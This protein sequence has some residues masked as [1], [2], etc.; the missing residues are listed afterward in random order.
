MPSLVRCLGM[1]ALSGLLPAAAFAQQAPQRSYDGDIQLIRPVYG[2]ENLPG[3]DVPI[4]WRGGSAR[5]G[6]TFMYEYQPLMLREFGEEVGPIIANRF[7]AYAGVSVDITRAVTARITMP[8]HVNW[9]TQVP[10][11][12][13]D[14]F[15][16]GDLG[17]GL[18]WAFLRKPV[19]SLGLRLDIT[20]P[21]SR[22]GYYAGDR[23]PR[24]DPG[25]LMAFR[26]GPRVLLA[27]DLGAR[28]RFQDVITSEDLRLGSELVWNNGLRIT[29]IK[30]RL[31]VGISIYARFG[32]LDFFEAGESSGEALV[33]VAYKAAPWLWVDLGAGRGFTQGYG[34]TDVRGYASLRFQRRR[35]EYDEVED[36]TD[37]NANAEG[38]KGLD[39][40]LFQPSDLVAA[41]AEREAEKD[42]WGEGE[43]AKVSGERIEI[44]YALRF[45]VGTAQLLPES[46]AT[47]DYVADLLNSDA[48]IA[49]LVIEGHASP[50]GPFELNYDLSVD[51]A[52]SIW[53]RLVEQK[54]HP[55]RL[56]F[57]GMGEVLPVEE[58][59]G[60]DEL[61][62]SRRVVFTITRQ[63]E[64]WEAAPRYEL[65]LAYPWNGEEY[66][67]IQPEIPTDENVPAPPPE[68]RQ[69]AERDT[70]LDDV[71]FDAPADDEPVIEG[72]D[73]ADDEPPPPNDEP[74][75]TG[76]ELSELPEESL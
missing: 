10:R 8:V 51:R 31:D 69:P 52:K 54:V 21:T 42:R 60:M 22:P 29:A 30:D 68:V 28:V 35:F 50:E 49:H 32:F 11:F 58:T 36:F 71:S 57:R 46:Y 64:N 48:R 23:L 73:D 67:A 4:N 55:S 33:N 16:Q 34:S 75:A 56:S 72:S 53:R 44:R 76:D 9:G 24:L 38:D 66:Q 26:I 14:G 6:L 25:F 39:F 27:S 47:L 45:K 19:V 59:G 15:A 17:L 61:G 63:L 1:L 13:A 74:P 70:S 43:F 40:R 41:E 5:W 62:A 18:H 12:A 7:T 2:P 3:I 20:A 37:P 65:D